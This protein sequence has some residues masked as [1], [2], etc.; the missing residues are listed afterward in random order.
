VPAP[1]SLEI[2]ALN[3]TELAP[4]ALDCNSFAFNVCRRH[5]CR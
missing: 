4:C 1:S 2:A 3:S 5:Y